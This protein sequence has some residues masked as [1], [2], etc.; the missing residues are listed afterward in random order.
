MRPRVFAASFV[1]SF[2][3]A[4]VPPPAEA[5][6]P[7]PAAS[8]APASTGPDVLDQLL[9]SEPP[10][11]LDS[12]IQKGTLENGLTYYI[13]PHKKPEKRAQLWLAVNAGAVLE[14]DDQRG[15]AHFIE[16]MCF[17]GTKR[18]PKAQLVDFL[19][20]AGMR[21]GADLNAYTAFDETVYKIQVP[22][23]KPE[24]LTKGINMLRDFADGVTFDPAEVEK[25]RGVVIEEWRG[26]RTADLRILDKQLPVILNGSKYAE[27]LPIG[28][29]ETIK[30][31]PRDTLV[32]FYKDWYRPDL[33]AVIAVGD[34]TP[35][36]VEAKV[37]ADFASLKGPAKERPRPPIP[38]AAQQKNAVSIETDPE[39][40]TTTLTL[41]APIPHRPK[42]SAK[43]FRRTL[44]ETLFS[45]MLNARFDE[46][47]HS[48]DAPYLL[49]ASGMGPSLARSMD[50]FQEIAVVKE[51]T[52]Q[53]GFAS[54]V[55]EM[56]RVERHGF[57]PTELDRA[58]SQVLR[59]VQ[60]QA[61]ERD[62]RD[63]MLL[64]AAIVR[65]FLTEDYLPAPETDVALT[66]K[67]LPTVTLDELNK[68]G[69]TM[70]AGNHVITYAGPAKQPKPT[71]EVLLATNK[72]V[73]AREIKPYEDAGPAQPLMAQPPT[74]GPVVKTSS[75]AEIGVTEW[76]L[77]NGVRV[78]VK[79]TTFS[80]DEV[81]MSAFSP[82]GHS[83]AKDADF[84]TAR[85]ASI[86]TGQGG[87]GSLDAVKLRKSLAGKVLNVAA[88]ISELQEGLFGAA[89]PADL[90]TMFQMIHLSFTAPRRDENAFLAWRARE[91]ESIKNRRVSAQTVFFEDLQQFSSQN[92]LR[93][94]PPTPESL[95]KVDLDKALAFYKDR[96]ADA[97]DFTFVLVGN[98]DLERTK[99]LSETYLGSLPTKKRKET[100]RD[101]KVSWPNGAQNKTVIKGTEP[102]SSV[103]LTFHGPEKW[104]RDGENDIRMLSEVLRIRL[105][106]VLREDM[107][108]TYSVGVGGGL[109]RRPKQEYTFTVSFGCAPENVDKLV[110]AVFDE[111]KSIQEKGIGE[112]YITKAKEIHRRTH[113]T[114]LKNNAFWVRELE[115]AYNYGDDPK[116]ILDIA[117]LV[118]KASSDRVRAAAKRYAASKQYVL[119]VLK[120]E[121]APSP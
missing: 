49:A 96:F 24:M 66:E 47:R 12:R 53:Q 116:L 65:T 41:Q 73:A 27:R 14:D 77:K 25:E 51:S 102:K 62:K 111:L 115:R 39:L 61:K 75:I 28:K 58:K 34:F 43:D 11:P 42:K 87:L 38:V 13:L 33:M 107:G 60:Q 29:P 3:A 50:A 4:C 89:S 2:L 103:Q 118:D 95:Q 68:L 79:P 20:K 63:G 120:P 37:K 26:R 10:L 30:S 48:P 54:L 112:T 67:Y 80:N 99:A 31:A 9:A 15:L 92:H 7:K 81:R 23:D 91:I 97:S 113:E 106:E 36:D 98:L 93:R 59:S 121:A 84:D 88:T 6:A 44:T 83:L 85:Y 105:L 52:V 18:F 70:T 94:R 1:L 56:L 100:W 40:A 17:N 74:P 82:G 104:S 45:V 101:I 76:T 22:T 114:N 109:S 108:G 21:F 78:I 8:A 71:P 90:E 46:I 5:P 110:K 117:S 19:E 57:T 119:G 72:A 16:H 32:R 55:E 69:K 86:V 64:A 35:A